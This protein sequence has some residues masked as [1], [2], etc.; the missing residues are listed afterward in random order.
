M[1]SNG[2]FDTFDEEDPD[3]SPNRDVISTIEDNSLEQP[4]G[5]PFD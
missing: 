2:I 4:Q 5:N 1:G 3:E